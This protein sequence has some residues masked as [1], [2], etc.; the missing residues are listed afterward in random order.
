MLIVGTVHRTDFC[1]L[2]N[3]VLQTPASNPKTSEQGAKFD[4]YV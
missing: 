4:Y 3:A 1:V 2:L